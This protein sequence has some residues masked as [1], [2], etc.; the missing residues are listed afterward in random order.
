MISMIAHAKINIGL[1]ILNKREDGYHNLETTFSTISLADEIK[2]EESG[3]TIEIQ[4]PGLKIPQSEN[5][6]DKAVRLIRAECN[7]SKGVRIS[8]KKRIPI[9][10]GLG[11][12]SADAAAVLKG[13]NKM[14]SLSISDDQLMKLGRKLG[15]DVPFLV[16]GGAAYARG[17]GEELTFFKLPKMRLLIYYPGYPVSTKWAYEEYDKKV[18][19]SMPEM[20]IINGKK[21]KKPRVGMSISNDFEPF[22]FNRYP[23][24]MDVKSHMLANGAFLVSLSGSG[25]CVYAVVDDKMKDKLIKY[26]IGIDAIYFDAETI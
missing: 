26:L 21:K 16:R 15:C 13:L 24:L 6:C 23:D 19:T 4:C 14:W 11:G 2:L 1:K 8:V 17:L 5:I 18:L 22:V 20:D 10:G 9:G 12:G 25:S 7:I 3:E